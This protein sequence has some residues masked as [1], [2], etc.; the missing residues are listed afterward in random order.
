MIKFYE[1]TIS[2]HSDSY[3]ISSITLDMNDGSYSI[4]VK[5]FHCLQKIRSK[6]RQ[7]SQ[8]LI[9]Q[10]QIMNNIDEINENSTKEEVIAYLEKRIVEEVVKEYYE[11]E[12]EAYAQMI[13]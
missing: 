7:S 8:L 11:R 2:K 12:Q 4:D 13:Y 9:L 1:D 5:Q 6:Y 3:H 10:M